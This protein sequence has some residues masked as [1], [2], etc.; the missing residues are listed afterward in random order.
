MAPTEPQSQPLNIAGSIGTAANL[1]KA[2]MPHEISNLLDEL[3]M[4]TINS[5]DEILMLGDRLRPVL[6][7]ELSQQKEQTEIATT[8]DMGQFLAM[9]L[10]RVKVNNEAAQD[11][12]TRLEL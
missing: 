7:N 3:N 1:A 5:Q 12:R 11:L 4:A 6:R 8:T 10:N 2:D 9:L